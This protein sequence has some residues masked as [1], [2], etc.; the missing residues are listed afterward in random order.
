MPVS[1]MLASSNDNSYSHCTRIAIASTRS[2]VKHVETSLRDE[3]VRLTGEVEQ[4]RAAALRTVQLRIDALT[5]DVAAQLSQVRENENLM[6][7]QQTKLRAA[8]HEGVSGVS[9]ESRAL[10]GRVKGASFRSVYDQKFS[11]SPALLETDHPRALTTASHLR[12]RCACV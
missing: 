10:E 5:R 11:I 12:I 3:I 4:S 9:A 7:R 2:R 1:G 6:Q 8:V